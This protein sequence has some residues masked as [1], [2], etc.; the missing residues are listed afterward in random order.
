MKLY[1]VP[2]KFWSAVFLL[3]QWGLKLAKGF[4]IAWLML[5]AT[6]KQK[7]SI[8]DYWVS[9]WMNICLPWSMNAKFIA[10]HWRECDENVKDFIITGGKTGAKDTICSSR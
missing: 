8:R 1:G 9:Q 2:A 3:G 10:N 4:V 5:L 6:E 7:A